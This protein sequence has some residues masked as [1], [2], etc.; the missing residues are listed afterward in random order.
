MGTS[1]LIAAIDAQLLILVN[2]PNS[3]VD[4]QDGDVRISA[5]QKIRELRQLRNQL[6][7]DQDADISIMEFDN[8]V[9][10]FGNLNGSNNCNEE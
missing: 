2:D 7:S 4:F 1:G 5:S 8:G 9:D 6:M 10:M 3:F